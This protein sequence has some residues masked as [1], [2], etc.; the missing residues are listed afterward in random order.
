LNEA[1]RKA[2]QGV[3]Y[4]LPKQLQPIFDE[5]MAYNRDKDI[6]GYDA[7]DEAALADLEKLAKKHPQLSK[8]LV[9]CAMKIHEGVFTDI[10]IDWDAGGKKR[11]ARMDGDDAA[12]I[13]DTASKKAK[14]AERKAQLQAEWDAI[15]K[16][17]AQ[18]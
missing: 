1:K 3:H 8:H 9:D 17:E 12:Q 4:A 18:A 10:N 6:K 14:F 11:L 16:A 15:D 13:L 5:R 2:D 7:A